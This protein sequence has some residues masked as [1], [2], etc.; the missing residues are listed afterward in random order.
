MLFTCLIYIL[1][2][3]YIGRFSFQA[4]AYLCNI[5][6]PYTNNFPSEPSGCILRTNITIITI[7]HGGES[8]A[9]WWV[10]EDAV[11]RAGNDM[12]VKSYYRTTAAVDYQGM[13]FLIYEAIREKPD[14]LVVSM[15]DPTILGPPVQAAIKAGIPVITINS[16]YE[17]F[18]SLGALHHIGQDETVA[19]YEGC[20]RLIS[21]NPLIRVI[22][23][24]DNEGG[25]NVGVNDRATGCKQAGIE[26]GLGTNG[27]I[28][29]SVSKILQTQIVSVQNF[30]SKNLG[31][32]NKNAS[33]IAFLASNVMTVQVAA[34][35]ATTLDFPPG[36]MTIG[37]FDF[38]QDAAGYMQQ[39]FLSFAIDQQQYL[40]GY[41]PVVMLVNYASTKNIFAPQYD[42]ETSHKQIPLLTGPQFITVDKIHQKGCEANGVIY[43]DDPETPAQMDLQF[44]LMYTLADTTKNCSCIDRSNITIGFVH[45]GGQTDIFWLAVQNGAYQA[46]NDMGV[47]LV[48]KN[49]SLADPDGSAGTL[50]LA[51]QL[52]DE[53]LAGLVMTIPSDSFKQVVNAANSKDLAV[54]AINT[55]LQVFAEYGALLFVG[56]KDEYA[57]Y[58]SSL[59]LNAAIHKEPNTSA[60]LFLCLDG[61]SGTVASYTQRCNGTLQ[62]LKQ[63]HQHLPPLLTNYGTKGTLY[64]PKEGTL[65]L[66]GSDVGNSE[67]TLRSYLSE[68]R[69]TCPNCN[70]TGMIAMEDTDCRVAQNQLISEQNSHNENPFLLACF[71]T[72]IYSIQGVSSGRAQFAVSQQ[73]WLQGYFPVLLLTLKALNGNCPVF[74]NKFVATGPMFTEAALVPYKECENRYQSASNQEYIG[75]TVCPILK[76][77]LSPSMSTIVEK[78]SN[79]V[80]ISVYALSGSMFLVIL[81]TAGA[82]FHYRNTKLIKASTLSFCQMMLFFMVLMLISAVLF[83]TN[84]SDRYHICGARPW[85]LTMSLL[86][87]LSPLFAKTSRLVLLFNNEKMKKIKITNRK[88]LV[89]VGKALSGGLAILI[90]WFV[91]EVPHQSLVQVFQQDQLIDGVQYTTITYQE[92]CHQQMLFVWVLTAYILGY[93]LYGSWLAYQVRNIP[94]AFNE[95]KSIGVS[96]YFFLVMGALSIGLLVLVEAN[97][98]AV[99]VL[100]SYGLII[101]VLTIWATL[102]GTKLHI[103]W[104]GR[105][106][107]VSLSSRI[108]SA[109]QSNV[110]NLPFNSFQ[111]AK[112]ELEKSSESENNQLK[113]ENKRLNEDLEE[114]KLEID[115]LRKQLALFRKDNKEAIVHPI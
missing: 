31:F 114:A 103:L 90:G 81:F 2:V 98:N 37:C 7:T 105:G 29:L 77:P 97:R 83:S 32:T 20:K 74:E 86:G 38:S 19:G 39:G 63:N 57:G 52:V 23:V 21:L 18:Q 54:I 34:K 70:V 55:G 64:S 48:L 15:P 111:V 89:E 22:L 66:I 50:T 107:L 35:I 60:E 101:T 115:E 4:E 12:G 58:Q 96:L 30:I 71:D 59:Q 6:A 1:L 110:P 3:K 65:Y 72:G 87:V 73:Q 8:D 25:Q 36:D 84:P 100:I 91:K 92:Q 78:I 41:L 46:A 17:V 95:S 88:L 47:N 13:A 43:C 76:K 82:F 42:N 112:N 53:K 102:F 44:P 93:V 94:E 51:R 27:V 104:T 9:F 68:L 28:Q 85:I 69:Q 26:M 40:Q 14:G 49:T 5:P 56:Q 45:N 11:L 24:P 67:I 106:D 61:S 75:W 80:G 108:S 99:A 62:W 16:G 79:Q 109:N 10:V 113:V 33:Q